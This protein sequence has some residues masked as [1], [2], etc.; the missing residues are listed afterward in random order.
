MVGAVAVPP[1]WR[2]VQLDRKVAATHYQLRVW[3]GLL[4]VEAHADNSMTLLARPVRVDLQQ[5]PILCWRW[6]VDAPVSHADMSRKQGDDYAARV[7]VG[8]RW[9]DAQVGWLMRTQRA[10]ARARY[11]ADMPDV[12]LNYVWDNQH[13]IGTWQANAYTD[14]AQMLVVE[15]GTEH[16]GQWM[17]ARRDLLAD[18]HHAFAGSAPRL[19]LLALAS[20]T[21][22][23]GERAHAG[24]A[25]LHW[26]ARDQA[27]RFSPL[28]TA[29]ARP[30]SPQG[31]N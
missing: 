11:G 8:F 6:R 20:D 9:P 17:S 18:F 31:Q 22:N 2:Q 1:P 13:P 14:Q 19:T 16:V 3:E 12:A 28:G 5:T 25:E 21:D 24:F 27:C 7:Y 26:V 4:A 23:T 10:W 30:S 29:E 15:S